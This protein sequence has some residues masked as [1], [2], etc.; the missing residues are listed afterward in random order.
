MRLWRIW[1]LAL[2][3][4]DFT[5]HNRLLVHITKVGGAGS[6]CPHCSCSSSLARL[7]PNVAKDGR[8]GGAAVR[9]ASR[10]EQSSAGAGVG[11]AF[12]SVVPA[13]M[14][15]RSVQQHF[16]LVAHCVRPSRC[17]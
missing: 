13:N 10:R 14:V 15:F 4:C 1:R 9:C 16:K 17:L 2:K 11:P 12:N 8:A 5:T 6:Y 7:Q 3:G